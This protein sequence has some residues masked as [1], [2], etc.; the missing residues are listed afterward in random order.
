[1]SVLPL[2]PPSAAG[3]PNPSAVV[4][5]VPP[6]R[7]ALDNFPLQHPFD[8]PT[9]AE[10]ALASAGR[11][12]R[13][14]IAWLSEHV[15]TLDRVVYPVAARHLPVACSALRSQRERSRALALLLRRLHAQLDG[16][17]AAAPEDVPS[18]RRTVLAALHEHTAGEREMTAEL[19]AALTA[20]QWQS[21][22]GS[23]AARL[24]HGPTRPH[25]H[26]P[27][28]GLAGR[29]AYR[30]S[31]LVDRVLDVLDSRAARPVPVVPAS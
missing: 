8:A 20:A 10:V 24:Q 21:L 17:G 28:S 6:P 9:A 29:I 25:P 16:D 5:L 7:A 26:T 3:P 30:V 27:R 18:L 31:A 22:A 12:D 4:A 13:D 15:A 1:M 11:G 23:Y 14:A 2:A 19:R